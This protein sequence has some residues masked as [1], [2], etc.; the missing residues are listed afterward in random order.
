MVR[1][2][3]RVCAEVIQRYE[4]HIAQLLGDGL[5]VYFGYPRA[6][7]DDA[8]PSRPYRVRHYQA[9]GA[10]N[11]R[12]EQDKGIELAVRLGIH[13]GLVMVGE[14]GGGGRQEQL[15][16]GEM[17]NVAALLQGLAEPNTVAMSAATY[18][19]VHGYFECQALGEQTLRGVTEP[20]AVYCVLR[21]SGA[22]SRLEVAATRG[23]TPLVGREQEVALLLERWHQVK[24]GQG[25]VILLSGEGGI[26]KSRLVQVLKDYVTSE[27]HTRWECR[28]SLYY[29][30][31]ALYP[32]IDLFQRALHWRQDA[33]PDE[34]L[35]K[36]EHLLSQYRLPL[37]ESVP[38]FAPLLSL[39]I[40]DGRY[41]PL[42]LSPQR[43]RQK[44]LESI[45]AVLMELSERRPVLFILE[46]LH[47]TD[48]TTLE[49]LALLLDQIP[50]APLCALLTCR[51]TF[52]LSWSHRSY[53]TEMTV[54]RL[55][56]DQIENMAEWVAGE[57]RL[58]SEVLEQIIE[59][60]DGVPLFVE[61]MTKAV[62]ESGCLK[63]TNEHYALIDAFPALAIP[64]TL[65]D[66][67]MAR[68]D[69]LMTAKV[70]AQ[71]GAVIGRRFSYELL[72]AVSQ[73]DE[74]TL[75]REL[76]RL[77][78]AELLY[79]RGLPPQATY[80][81]K[82]ALVVDSAYQSLLKSTRQQY[83]RRIAQV[84]EE[85]FPETAEMQPEL[86]AHHY[87]ETGLS[88]KAVHYWQHAGQRAIQRSAHAEA[89]HHLTQGLALLTTLPETPA[90]VLQE[91]PLLVALGTV[92]IAA[93]GFAAP[94]VEP[95]YT[96]AYALC[97][98]SE[99]A[100][101]HFD[102]LLARLCPFIA[103]CGKIDRQ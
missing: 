9:L 17:P 47:W 12:L 85:Q 31:S 83:H 33:P 87:R 96:R 74:A 84:L 90:R 6:H 20:I 57:K 13:T 64:A 45:V 38:L 76:S 21:E 52:Q 37:E 73:L 54:N 55:S 10:L 41:P 94:E 27:A 95:V 14:M 48:P 98:Q 16:M 93:K 68:L 15:A 23:L 86:L 101:H 102:L 19:L 91:L 36:L 63:E 1:E 65:Q 4:G 24:A 67:L 40:P 44:T 99:D 43:H 2:Y 49:F 46:D 39:P 29:Q 28:G 100:P 82:H 88:E 59:K 60:T 62:L 3:Q 8:Q 18:H 25:Q 35:E 70:I 22:Q 80:T 58:P 51:P 72:Q 71:L 66:S 77:V 92:L 26:G 34:R 7:E 30:N 11:T 53:L 56:R 78:E 75:Q 97:Q 42:H 89:I 32:I 79:Q 69:R 103:I 50:T 61:E 81:F 5:L